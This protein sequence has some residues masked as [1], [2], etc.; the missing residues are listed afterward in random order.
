MD[1]EKE[2]ENNFKKHRTNYFDRIE[3]LYVNV[4]ISNNFSNSNRKKKICRF[5]GL[6]AKIMNPYDTIIYLPVIT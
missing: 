3:K 5:I 2:M 1:V 4:E 6:S